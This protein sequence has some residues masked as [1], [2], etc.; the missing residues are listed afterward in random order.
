MWSVCSWQS[1]V[2]SDITLIEVG[3][4]NP[5]CC[6]QWYGPQMCQF[7]IDME[8]RPKVE[9]FASCLL[10]AIESQGDDWRLRLVHITRT[11]DASC[12]SESSSYVPPMSLLVLATLNGDVKEVCMLRCAS[13]FILSHGSIVE[14]TQELVYLA[15]LSV[16]LTGYATDW[17]IS[18]VE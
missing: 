17:K 16:L 13:P 11:D 6:L 10:S 14:V 15:E 12:T 1:E 2:E 3:A 18:F 8:Q 7:D 9:A 5:V 4:V